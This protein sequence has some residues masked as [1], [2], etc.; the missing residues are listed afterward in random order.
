V[1]RN[2]YGHPSRLTLSRLL[3]HG[4]QVWRTDQDGTVTITSDGRWMKVA[5]QDRVV[6]YNVR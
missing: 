3:R 5:A 6:T 4:I 1:G 2:N